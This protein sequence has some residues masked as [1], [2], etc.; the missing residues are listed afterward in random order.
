MTDSFATPED[1]AAFKKHIH[2]NSPHVTREQR[3]YTQMLTLFTHLQIPGLKGSELKC[4]IP[5]FGLVDSNKY[6]APA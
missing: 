5:D 1:Y 4:V 2:E 3:I 6:S